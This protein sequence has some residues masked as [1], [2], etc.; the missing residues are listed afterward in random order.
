MTTAP[1]SALWAVTCLFNPH[2]YRRRYANFVQFR[3]TLGLPLVAVELSFDGNFELQA[4][5]AEI[6]VRVRGGDV[7]WQKERLL[8]IGFSH[9]P[10][11]C[12]FVAVLDSDI[13]FDNEDWAADA[14]R[15]MASHA[16]IQPFDT[17][18]FLAPDATLEHTTEESR[19]DS[20]QRSAAS[21][22]QLR[23]NVASSL[24]SLVGDGHGDTSPGL[25]W[26]FRREILD[27]HG[28]FDGC[29]IGGGDTALA[30][31]ALGLFDA[32]E[33]RHQMNQRQRDFYRAWAEPF[34]RDVKGSVAALPG[35]L[36]ALWH[37]DIARRR[38]GSRHSTLPTHSF[39]P[40]VDIAG[41]PGEA[42]RWSS[43]KPALRQDLANYFASRREDG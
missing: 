20:E 16:I 43:D 21:R 15:L 18:R 36:E 1:S 13:A 34:R 9:L 17:A 35:A 11:E 26:V 40:R 10:P 3:R 8:N 12:R 27:R 14:E 39:D 7:M 23:E 37:G 19:I 41:E 33:Q 30:C 5:D 42:W 31:A 32:V 2:K 6:L 29:V 38:S 4:A 25:A 28:L 24:G 22:W